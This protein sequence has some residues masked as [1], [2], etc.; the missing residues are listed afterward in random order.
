[1]KIRVMSGVT[2]RGHGR[3]AAEARENK[4][5]EKGAPGCIPGMQ[6][7]SCPAAKRYAQ[8]QGPSAS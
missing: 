1:M 2:G 3:K 8:Q 5:R 7:A 4:E 6:A